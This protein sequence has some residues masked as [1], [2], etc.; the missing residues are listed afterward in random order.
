MIKKAR[1]KQSLLPTELPKLWRSRRRRP[2]L[3]PS[4]PLPPPLCSYKDNDR[5]IYVSLIMKHIKKEGWGKGRWEG[6][7]G[8]SGTS[9]HL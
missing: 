1:A 4:L 9:Y 7:E 3:F 6:R 2:P 5:M 8:Q